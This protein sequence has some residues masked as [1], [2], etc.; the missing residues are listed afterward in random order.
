MSKIKH[1]TP[2]I[3]ARSHEKQQKKEKRK[4]KMK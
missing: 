3:S 4:R 1:K 2:K